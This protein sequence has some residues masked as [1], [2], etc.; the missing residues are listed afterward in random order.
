MRIIIPDTNIILHEAHSIYKFGDN[1]IVLP[2]IVLEEID[3]KKRNQD[4]V[5][6]N[7]RAFSRIIDNLRKEYPGK[8]NHG[9]P[10]K[11]GGTLRVELNH[12]SFERMEK[13]FNEKTNDNRIIAVA[14]NLKAE[15]D[16]KPENERKEVVLVTN[17]MLAGVKADTLGITVEKYES[18]RLIGKL[19]EVHKGHQEV[20][21]PSELMNKFFE[22]DNLKFSE[23]EE[24][25]V[26]KE[27]YPQDFLILKN[28]ENPSSSALGRLIEVN[29]ELKLITFVIDTDEEIWNIKARNAQQRMFLELLMDPNVELV[30][31]VGPAG[32][33]KTL[34][35]LAASLEQT[36]NDN[37]YKKILVARPVIPMGKDIG[38]L[39][40]DMNEKLRPWM[41]P[42]F[43]NLEFLFDID[44]NKKKGTIEE[45]IQ[46]INLE[47]EALTYIRGRSIP[48]QFIILD[49]IQN[50][51][52]HEIKT[53][54]TRAGEGTKIILLGDPEQIDHPYLDSTNNALT[55][56]IEKMKHLNQVGIIKLEKTERSKLADLAAKLL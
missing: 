17:D 11:T 18:D 56:V 25:L 12:V 5:G 50:M 48:Q 54:I 49:E 37:L 46:G 26:N 21:V 55:Y 13:L 29:N 38:Y 14:L 19:E 22:M 40:G 45:A 24:Y 36:E 23:I 1:E 27:V 33:G 2:A 7:A 4:E 32:T 31:G 6:R 51:S 52:P 35:A 30:C 8:L 43:D 10:L 44:E 39:P 34:L 15:E 20:F 41:Q 9:V 42:I 53:V 28:S 3:S 16:E 47:I